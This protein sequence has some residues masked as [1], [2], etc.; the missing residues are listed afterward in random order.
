MSETTNIEW[1]DATFNPWI[2]C[3][4]VSPGCDHCYAEV[5]TPARVKRAAGVETWGPHGQR[6]RTSARNWKQPLEWE[7]G[8]A[9]FYLQHGRRRRVFCASLADVFDNAVPQAWRDDLWDLIDATPNLDWL[10]LTKRVG[11]VSNMLPVPFDF[12]R[13]YPHVWLGITVVNQA[14]ADRDVP[15]LLRVPARVRFLSVE[16]MLGPINLGVMDI[17]GH[18]EIYPLLGTT[19]CEDEDGDAAPDVPPLN[20]VIC[21][22][23]SGPQ[24]RPMHP[25]WARS[26]RDQCAAAGVPYLFKQH[27]E[28]REPL[29]GEA[30]DT[31]MGRAAK[32]PAFIVSKDNG[33][34][35]CFHSSHIADGQAVI[36]VGKKAAGRLLDGV[37]H[38]GF[39]EVRHG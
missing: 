28:W 37:E 39:P 38:N 9:A 18:S 26:L 11:N 25:D 27:G 23:E 16:P 1:C 32:P 17:D 34:V 10:L 31:S 33:T 7:R 4:K 2:G 21:G 24:A 12:D 15:K 3:T 6:Q 29:E 20:W 5:S 19:N 14:E 36:R 22:G 8:H 35:H 30:F 13:L